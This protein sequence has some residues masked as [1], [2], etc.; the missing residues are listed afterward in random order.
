ML[1]VLRIKRCI[2]WVWVLEG[3][4]KLVKEWDIHLSNVETIKPKTGR[5]NKNSR[6]EHNNIDS[7]CSQAVC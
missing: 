4:Y 1:G 5:D 3:A 7:L 6:T 2:R